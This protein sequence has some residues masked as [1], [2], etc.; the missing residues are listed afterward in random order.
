[1]EDLWL[2][3]EDRTERHDRYYGN[4]VRVVPEIG[5]NEAGHATEREADE[6]AGC[7]SSTG[8]GRCEHGDLAAAAHARD[9]RREHHPGVA[10]GIHAM[11]QA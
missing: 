7:G 9:E 5:R 8:E 1:M 6:Q 3:Q 10:A 4:Y 2:D 11:D